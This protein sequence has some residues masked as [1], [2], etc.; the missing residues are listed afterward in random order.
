VLRGSFELSLLIVIDIRPLALG[1]SVH[2]E[3][4]GSVPE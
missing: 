2:E 3:R 4:R 1:E